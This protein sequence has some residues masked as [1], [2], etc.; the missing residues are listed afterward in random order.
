MET[1]RDIE[2]QFMRTNPKRLELW[3]KQVRENTKHPNGKKDILNLTDEQALLRARQLYDKFLDSVNRT[4]GSD[5]PYTEKYAEIQKLRDELEQQP[6]SNPVILLR[7]CAEPVVSCYMIYVRQVAHFN[8]VKA[9]IEIYLATA[10]TGRLPEI[11]PDG[12]PKDPYSGQDFEYEKTADG[13][14][15]RCRVKDVYEGKVWQYEFKVRKAD[16]AG[17]AAKAGSDSAEGRPSK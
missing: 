1:N 2:L 5:T 15:L 7:P 6:V 16:S 3:R 11:L 17:A 10:K 4:I 9:A 8:A 12:L 13:F 14:V